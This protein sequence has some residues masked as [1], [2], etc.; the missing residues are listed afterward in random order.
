MKR[1]RKSIL[2]LSSSTPKIEKLAPWHKVKIWVLKQKCVDFLF[3][4]KRNLT[5]TSVAQL[6]GQSPSRRKVA[7]SIPVG[8]H[9]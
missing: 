4:N 5:L 6:V 1:E 3:L 7:S 8:S 9:A 2:V